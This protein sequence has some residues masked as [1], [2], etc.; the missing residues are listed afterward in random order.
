MTLFLK[1]NFPLN[2]RWL[3]Q[4][5]AC[6]FPACQTLIDLAVLKIHFLFCLFLHLWYRYFNGLFIIFF[7]TLYHEFFNFFAPHLIDL[8]NNFFECTER[9][10]FGFFLFSYQIREYTKM[11]GKFQSCFLKQAFSS[12][13]SS[14]FS[15]SRSVFLCRPLIEKVV[16]RERVK[17]RIFISP[18]INAFIIFSSS[19]Q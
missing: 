5:L 10:C 2:F 8:K 1:S 15:L 3:F 7:V 11:Y 6:W 14:R 12:L 13:E 16:E 19:P 4:S 17:P 18:R 9:N